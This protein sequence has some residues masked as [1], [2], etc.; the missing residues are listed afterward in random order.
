MPIIKAEHPDGRHMMAVCSEA[1]RHK[2][3]ADA[4]REGFVNIRDA[5]T[6]EIYDTPIN[7]TQPEPRKA[8]KRATA[9]VG[10]VLPDGAVPS[11]FDSLFTHLKAQKGIKPPPGYIKEGS[12]ADMIPG[13]PQ[14]YD[15][16]FRFSLKCRDC[17]APGAISYNEKE[18]GECEKTNTSL[19]IA[20]TR[21]QARHDTVISQHSH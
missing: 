18:C 15:Q 16:V 12:A 4:K 6:G 10:A 2:A 3:I 8:H 17:N 7:L 21:C 1:Q 5:E 20:C 11:P 9:A 13:E 14:K 19:V